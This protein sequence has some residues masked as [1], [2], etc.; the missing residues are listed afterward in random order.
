MMW[1]Q[2]EN[3]EAARKMAGWSDFHRE[4]GYHKLGF[5]HIEREGGKRGPYLCSAFTW[6]KDARGNYAHPLVAQGR[7]TTVIAALT[8]AYLAAVEVNEAYGST[9]A[10]SWLNILNNPRPP[11]PLADDVEDMLGGEPVIDYDE[12]LG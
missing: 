11:E 4:C 10:V 3:L 7:G 6:T 8:A 1:R 9:A 2:D 12:M 5:D